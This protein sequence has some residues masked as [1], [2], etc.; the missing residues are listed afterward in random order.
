MDVVL[1]LAVRISDDAGECERVNGLGTETL[2]GE[3]K[4]S[5]VKRFVSLSNCAVYGWT[6]HRGADE[7]GV[8]VRPATPVSR[9]RVRAERAVLSG[10]GT[11]LRSP[12]CSSMGTAETRVSSRR[13]FVRRRS[14]RSSSPEGR[15]RLSVIA[16]DELANVLEALSNAPPRTDLGG[17]FHVNDGHPVT[18]LE[19][20]RALE[21]VF[22]MKRPRWS[23]PYGVARW[24]MR[25]A[26]GSTGGLSASAAHRLFLVSHDHWYAADKLRARLGLPREA[27]LPDRLATYREWYEGLFSRRAGA[28]STGSEGGV[29]APAPTLS[30]IGAACSGPWRREP[31]RVASAPRRALVKYTL[32]MRLAFWAP[33]L[34]VAMGACSSKSTSRVS[35]DA[36]DQGAG[37]DGSTASCTSVG[38]TC[39][40][41]SAGC[42][43]LQQNPALCGNVILVC[44]LPPG[45]ETI[46]VP[47][48]GGGD[49]AAEVADAGE[50]PDAGK[51]PIP[52][53]GKI[54]DAGEK[55][56]GGGP[57]P[58]D[59][60]VPVDASSD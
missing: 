44:C 1:H 11:V 52:D 26:G 18:F 16:V 25:A 19:I 45:G 46:A 57:P 35:A 48:A 21:S 10:G 27:S 24:V 53:A 13:S 29:S 42:P 51:V 60:S 58:V 14:S 43:P 3:A 40:L 6:I 30:P 37:D 28:E 47:D 17:A 55:D 7:E 23:L 33:L 15:A 59:A 31:R 2:V 54:P 38:G 41:F 5:A 9:S 32:R 20:L 49:D 34:L 36:G 56:S 22:G 4:A 12:L 50:V 8:V 39:E